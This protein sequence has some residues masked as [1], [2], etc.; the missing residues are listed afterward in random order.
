MSTEEMMQ[1]KGMDIEERTAENELNV[2]PGLEISEPEETAEMQENTSSAEEFA[3]G[4][5]KKILLA[6]IGGCGAKIVRTF[7]GLA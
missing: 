1:E 4:T 6:G 5:R 2:L 7:T 3:S